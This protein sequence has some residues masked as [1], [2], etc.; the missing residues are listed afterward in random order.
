VHKQTASS[1]YDLILIGSGMGALTVASLMAQLRNKKVLVL[2]RHFKAGGYTHEFKRQQFHWDVGLHYVGMMNED[3]EERA[4][5][6]L[7]TGGSLQWMRLPDPMEVFIYPS[8]R[9]EVY[10]NKERYM[11]DL[12]QRFP[13]EKSAIRQYFRDLETTYKY[14]YPGYVF[15]NF[16][17]LP[18]RLMGFLYSLLHSSGVNITVK[19]YLDKHFKN[20][21]LKAILATRWGDVGL[22]P[23]LCGFAVHATVMNH[24]LDG[25]YY[26][27]KGG[28][29]IANSVQ[30]IV[31]D[32]GGKFLLNREVT[33]VLIENGK[34]VGVRVRK[35][36]AKEE[37]FEEYF[38]PSIVSDTGAANTYL[39]LIPPDYPVAFRE[40]LRRFVE[41]TEPTTS[42]TVYVG[43][44]QDPR[45]LGFHGEN[46]WIFNSLDHD[47]IYRRRGE[48]VKTAQ[49]THAYLCFPSL[50]DPE[51][52]AHTAIIL[53]FTDYNLF[54]SW[55]DQ[56]WLHRDEDY[57]T[58]KQQITDALI[59]FVNQHF[60]GFTDIVE[61]KELSTPVTMEHF[62]GHHHG[63]MYGL[64]FVPER[65]RKENLAWIR[66][67]TA[68]PGLYLT[69]AD[70]HCLGIVG[71]M[72]GGMNTL[73]EL[74]DGIFRP[75]V[76][77][78]TK[79]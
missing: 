28:G 77:A 79:K 45:K 55:R 52:T 33:Q 68:L 46:Y 66:P 48:W 65:F 73:S 2:E 61:Y 37:T 67:T 59:A 24:Y 36:N 63:A 30:K 27:A 64:P 40:P 47:D 26:P 62:T 71:A 7:I 72:M 18:M 43:L 35:V 6:N 22:P 53:A 44:S 17:N 8:L 42:V 69:G 51:A 5:C 60:P 9:F 11:A 75:E 50:K 56:P 34:A 32:K 23:G 54:A 13:E 20:P 1:N 16:S 15:K 58:L 14:G 57:Q 4:I 12:I 10:G 74:P 31:E 70:V 29:T 25:A 39:K 19:D 3:K 41:H 49:P 21:E 76:V 78:V 38:A